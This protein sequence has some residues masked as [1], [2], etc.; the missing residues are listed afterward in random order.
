VEALNRK[1]QWGAPALSGGSRKPSDT[2]LLFLV[3]VHL[4]M[5]G[6]SQAQA[7]RGRCLAAV[8]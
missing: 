5:L 6:A 7:E 4:L 3:A 1:R 8:G 2:E